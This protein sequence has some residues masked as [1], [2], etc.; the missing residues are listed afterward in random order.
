MVSPVYNAGE[1][2]INLLI[3]DGPL[4]TGHYRLRIMPSIRDAVDNPLDGNGHCFS[5]YAH[6]LPHLDQ[7]MI[8][9]QINFSANPD[10]TAGPDAAIL[11]L[12][13]RCVIPSRSAAKAAL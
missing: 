4:G 11:A 7:S 3:A 10:D 9:N 2:T 5:A 6:L 1:T 8:Y 13:S 12:N